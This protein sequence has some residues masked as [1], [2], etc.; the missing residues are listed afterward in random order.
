M[1]W[2]EHQGCISIVKVHLC[3]ATGDQP[4]IS[5]LMCLKGHDAKR[6]CRFCVVARQNY[7]PFL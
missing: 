4:A 7:Y 6:P 1:I 2:N 5:K 3:L